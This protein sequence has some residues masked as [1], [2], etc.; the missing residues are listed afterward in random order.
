MDNLNDLL[1]ISSE[2][3]EEKQEI[4]MCECG[5]LPAPCGCLIIELPALPPSITTL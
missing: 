1:G 4:Q 3:P 5:V 2:V